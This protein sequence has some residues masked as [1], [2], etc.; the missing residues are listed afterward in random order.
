[1]KAARLTRQAER[2]LYAAVRWLSAESP[3]AA[4]ELLSAVKK[5]LIRIAEFPESG[6]ERP[7]LTRQGWRLRDLRAFPFVVVVAADETPPAVVHILHT[8]RDL[9]VLLGG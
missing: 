8:S 2:E 1:V 6:A 5:L 7:D 3:A 9:K 4:R